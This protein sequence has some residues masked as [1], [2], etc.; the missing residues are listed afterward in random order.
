M[1]SAAR[2]DKVGRLDQTALALTT[3]AAARG[4]RWR[5]RGRRRAAAGGDVQLHPAHRQLQ[6][7]RAAQAADRLGAGSRGV[8]ESRRRRVPAMGGGTGGLYG[9]PPLRVPPATWR[10]DERGRDGSAEGRT[11]QLTVGP[12]PGGRIDPRNW[13][14]RP[15]PRA[16]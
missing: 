5:R 12:R 13:C 11:M 8:P 15:P 16:E 6:R 14:N 2:L 9:A 10:R 7:A 1:P 3:D 4:A